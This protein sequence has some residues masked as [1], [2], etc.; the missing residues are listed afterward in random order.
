MLNDG[1]K[2]WGIIVGEPMMETNVQTPMHTPRMVINSVDESLVSIKFE[3]LYIY[4]YSF[5]LCTC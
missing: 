4:T 1:E 3:V 5:W 2:T